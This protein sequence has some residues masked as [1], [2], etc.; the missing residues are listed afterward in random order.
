MSLESRMITM[1]LAMGAGIVLLM[2]AGVCFR[3]VDQLMKVDAHQEATR[4]DRHLPLRGR[5]LGYLL[6]MILLPL[7]FLAVF[8]G[9]IVLLGAIVG[10]IGLLAR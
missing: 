9:G 5:W 10:L 4:L 6:S 1:L 7:G 8:V 3:R 2:G